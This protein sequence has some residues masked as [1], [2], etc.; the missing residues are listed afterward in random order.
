MPGDARI[1]WDSGPVITGQEL[2]DARSR[3][4]LTQAELAQLLRHKLRTI[5][6]WE[7]DGVAHGK[8][9]LVRAALGNYL[10]A[11]GEQPPLESYSDWALVSEIMRRLEFG[12]TQSRG[13]GGAGG[14]DWKIGRGAK[15]IVDDA[16][17]EN[18]V[19]D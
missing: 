16:G 19:T 3:A 9:P 1:M 5:Q 4:N 14:P 12:A 18:D 13:S 15:R 17:S 7:R 6:N 11:A 10:R 8:E 2:R